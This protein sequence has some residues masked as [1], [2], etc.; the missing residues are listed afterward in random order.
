VVLTNI[1]GGSPLTR[2]RRRRRL[3]VCSWIQ[4]HPTVRALND[5]DAASREGRP[6]HVTTSTPVEI[7]WISGSPFSW[8]VLLTVEVKGVLW[9]CRGIVKAIR[10]CGLACG[11]LAKGMTK[12]SY[13]R[14]RFPPRMRAL[15]SSSDFRSRVNSD[16]R[17]RVL[18]ANLVSGGICDAGP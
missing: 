1:A 13:K 6:S 11:S 5:M 4:L 14:Y 7:Y 10:A 9:Y 2:C 18:P 3:L 12:I 17:D 15:K 8:R 16:F